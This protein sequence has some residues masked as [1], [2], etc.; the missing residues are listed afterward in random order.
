[1]GIFETKDGTYQAGSGMKQGGDFLFFDDTVMDGR[2]MRNFM[3]SKFTV[4]DHA[5]VGD[6]MVASLF[7][8]GYGYQTYSLATGWSKASMYLPMP[9]TGMIM[10]IDGNKMAG[11]ANLSLYASTGGG[12]VGVSLVNQVGTALSCVVVSAIGYVVLN[13]ITDGEWAI[14]EYMDSVTPQASA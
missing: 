14:A 2:S 5:L 3:R 12:V 10:V 4:T 1:M 13:C 8:V 6:S 7:T 11:N 9:S